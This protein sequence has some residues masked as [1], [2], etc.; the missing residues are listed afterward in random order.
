MERQRA[1][2]NAYPRV[3]D[4]QDMQ[5]SRLYITHLHHAI[6]APIDAKCADQRP[7]IFSLPR[8]PCTAST[9]Y[10]W[11]RFDDRSVLDMWTSWGGNGRRRTFWEILFW[12]GVT[13]GLYFLRIY[14]ILLTNAIF[15]SEPRTQ[16]IHNRL[17]NTVILREFG[18]PPHTHLTLDQT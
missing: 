10:A 12:R 6:V 17:S 11:F 2:N 9:P 1:W 8:A 4:R 13:Q 16:V 7:P 5:T 3:Y 14:Q 18:M 15:H